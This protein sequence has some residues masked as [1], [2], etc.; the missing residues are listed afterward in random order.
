MRFEG[1]LR[2]S[3]YRKR[4][5]KLCVVC[6]DIFFFIFSLTS[7][8]VLAESQCSQPTELAELLFWCYL[9]IRS[10]ADSFPTAAVALIDAVIVIATRETSSGRGDVGRQLAF[11]SMGFAIFGPLTGYL[12]TILHG[13]K[14]IYYLPILIHVGLM[15]LVAVIAL[16]SNDIPL[17]PPEWSWHT[18]CGML[19]LPMSAI[20]RYGSETAALFFVLMVMGTFWSTMDSYLPL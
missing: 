16:V 13:T 8:S 4:G 6:E 18:R 2:N 17:S 11:G 12:T 15:L 14:T 9:L 20:K 1:T 7:G 3:R 10:F 19:A 5:H